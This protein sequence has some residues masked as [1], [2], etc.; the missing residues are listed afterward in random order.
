MPLFHDFQKIR[1]LS[2]PYKMILLH[3]F[4]TDMLRIERHRL[5]KIRERICLIPF[6][7][8]VRCDP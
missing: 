2:Q 4:G 5:F 7:C 3:G 8:I 1:I 6:I